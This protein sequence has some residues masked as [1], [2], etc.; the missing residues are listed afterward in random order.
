MELMVLCAIE[1]FQPSINIL[2]KLI[3]HVK[4]IFFK[5]FASIL[6][7]VL[8][9]ESSK[10]PAEEGRQSR[11]QHCKSKLFLVPGCHAQKHHVPE[12]IT[13]TIKHKNI[14]L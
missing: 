8:P 10:R 6:K 2:A 1:I 4:W 11:G 9:N 13:A 7:Y 3:L 12:I 5:F 14:E